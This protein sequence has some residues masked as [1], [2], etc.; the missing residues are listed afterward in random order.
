M[1]AGDP[2]LCSLVSDLG[3]NID[4]DNHRALVAILDCSHLGPVH[5]TDPILDCTTAIPLPHRVAGIDSSHTAPI[6]DLSTGSRP[7][8]AVSIG[9]DQVDDARE[10]VFRRREEELIDV[11]VITYDEI[12][13]GQAKQIGRIILPGD[14]EFILPV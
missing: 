14:D 11:K 8:F 10:E 12:L 3:A 9:R 13:E 2:N 5:G 1:P 4:H 7:K 6:A